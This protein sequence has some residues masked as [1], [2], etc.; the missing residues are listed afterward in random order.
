MY[1]LG[2][3]PES[4]CSYD[5]YC[6]SCVARPGPTQTGYRL[7]ISDLGS[8]GVVPSILKQRL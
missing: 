8:G 7:E 6:M 1:D 5:R 3:Y 2:Q 4:R